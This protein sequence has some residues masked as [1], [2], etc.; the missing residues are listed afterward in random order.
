GGFVKFFG[1]YSLRKFFKGILPAQLIAFSTCSSSGTLPFTVE[2]NE[3]NLGISKKMTSFVLPLG[4]TINMDGTSLYQGVC[5]V[6]V[7]QVYNIDLTY[8]NYLTILFTGTFASIGTAGIPG[9]GLIMLSIML[10][11]VGLPIEGVGLI[12]GVDRLLD[13]GRTALN[14]TGDSAVNLVVAKSENEIHGS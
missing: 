2:C 11:S 12:A 10:G 7:A 9:G 6:F 14:I 4:A 3:Q 13:M 1:K 5:V 8:E